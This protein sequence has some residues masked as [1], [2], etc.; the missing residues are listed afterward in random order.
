MRGKQGA[1]ERERTA[2]DLVGCLWC[3]V[4]NVISIGSMTLVFS[5][6]PCRA[7]AAGPI[8][9]YISITQKHTLTH[10]HSIEFICHIYM[11]M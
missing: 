11:Y 6:V 10:A 1:S 8:Y 2:R 5:C 9:I 3:A 7:A 4:Q